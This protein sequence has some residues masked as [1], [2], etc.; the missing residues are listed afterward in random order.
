MI[1]SGASVTI[2]PILK[3]FVRSIKPSTL[4]SLQGLS[5][6]T[7][8]EGECTVC[9]TLRDALRQVHQL[10]TK[11]YYV[12]GANNRLFSPKQYFEESNTCPFVTF[13][14]PGAELGLN[15]GSILSFPFQ[16]DSRLP[17]MLTDHH[18]KQRERPVAGLAFQE[19]LAFTSTKSIFTSVADETNQNISYAHKELLIWHHKLCHLDLHRVQTFLRQPQE[20]SGHHQVLFPKRKYSSCNTGLRAAY[21]V[22]KQ[23]RESSGFTRSN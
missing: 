15:D 7:N 1:D 12:P 4:T 5:T 22:G 8:V 13:N 19:T 23:A 17:M 16:K 21:Q 3:D 18:F 10:R 9:W 6:R 14:K 20:G 2:T 11:A